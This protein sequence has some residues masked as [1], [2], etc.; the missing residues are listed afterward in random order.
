MKVGIQ[1]F[2]ITSLDCEDGEINR[3]KPGVLKS[4]KHTYVSESGESEYDYLRDEDPSSPKLVHRKY[5]SHLTAKQ[6][7][8]LLDYDWFETCDT[9]GSLSL[10]YGLIPA[11]SFNFEVGGYD[12][13]AFLNSYISAVVVNEEEL[14]GELDKL[15]KDT[16]EIKSKKIGQKLDR[17]HK[18]LLD[19]DPRNHEIHLPNSFDIDLEQHE[20]ILKEN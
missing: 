10:E 3:N 9:M 18:I 8:E 7:K 2:V 4:R 12:Y 5:C 19:A 20:L 14:C 17:I 11:V 16:A 15:D 6:V 13:T 1:Y